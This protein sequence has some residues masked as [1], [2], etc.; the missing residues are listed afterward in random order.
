MG[1]AADTVITWA[2]AGAVIIMDGTGAV[3]ITSTGII[4]VI[5]T[6]GENSL[7]SALAIHCP[8]EPRTAATRSVAPESATGSA[9]MKADVQPNPIST[10]IRIRSE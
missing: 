8:G 9:S 6:A 3:A 5:T 1:T 4:T 7:P 10:A 2:A